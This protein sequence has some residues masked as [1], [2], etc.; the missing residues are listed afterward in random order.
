MACIKD[1]S[2]VND[3]IILIDDCTDC[4]QGNFPDW[5]EIEKTFRAINTDYKA[6]R[7]DHDARNYRQPMIVYPGPW[8]LV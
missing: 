5:A 7:W 4:G 2:N 6:L 1:L 3:H 8:S